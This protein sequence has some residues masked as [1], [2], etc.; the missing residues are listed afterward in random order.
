MRV[1]DQ[2]DRE[3]TPDAAQEGA[4]QG[5]LARP[6]FSGDD[7]KACLAAETVF[8]QTEGD[9]MLAAE[10]QEVRVGQQTERLVLQLEESFVHLLFARLRVTGHDD[11]RASG[12][13]PAS[14]VGPASGVSIE[15]RAD[16]FELF[17][18]I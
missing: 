14:E 15:Q 13:S 9:R 8:E 10:K 3:F 2:A 1:R 16:N 4:H 12:V 17:Q 5:R 6:D 7:A 18:Q 11:A